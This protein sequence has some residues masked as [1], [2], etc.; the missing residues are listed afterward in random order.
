MRSHD[1]P[2]ARPRPISNPSVNASHR[3]PN[4][5]QRLTGWG[6]SHPS[7]NR[8][9]NAISTAP[10]N[11]LTCRARRSPSCGSRNSRRITP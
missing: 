7:V 9:T 3:S 1:I 2:V 8:N 6:R 10:V 5:H 11:T 4:V